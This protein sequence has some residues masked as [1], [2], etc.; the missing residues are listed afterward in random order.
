LYT[1]ATICLENTSFVK[2]RG[3]ITWQIKEMEKN[4]SKH[5]AGI[6]IMYICI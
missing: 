5:I 4:I 6:Y 1:V 2:F 3:L